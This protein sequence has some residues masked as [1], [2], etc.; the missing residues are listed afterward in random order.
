M[1]CLEKTLEFEVI[2]VDKNGNCGHSAT[3]TFAGK[4]VMALDSSIYINEDQASVDWAV[5]INSAGIEGAY[6]A[7]I[8]QYDKNNKLIAV[9]MEPVNF[10]NGEK[11]FG[12]NIVVRSN[13]VTVKLLLWDENLKPA[14]DVQS[15]TFMNANNDPFKGDDHVNVVFLGG[16]ITQG[17]GSSNAK[18]TCYAALTG[19]WFESTFKTAD[20]NV[21]WHNMGVGGTPS[22]YGLLRLN[23]DVVSKDP[24]IVFVEFAVNDSGSDTRRYMEGIVRSLLALEK[25]PYIVFL[26]TTNET[27]TTST[28]YHEQVAEFYGIPQISLKDAL[29]RELNGANAREAGYLKDSVHPSDLGYAVYFKE[30][31]KCLETGRYY[32]KPL[33]RS[34]KLVSQSTGVK[35]IF[36]SS[37]TADLSGG[38]WEKGGTAPKQFIKSVTPGDSFEFEFEGNILAL[39]HGLNIVGGKYDV[40]VDDVKV[41]TGET[42]YNNIKSNQLVLGYN[43]FNLASKGKHKAKIV[44]SDQ[45]NPNSSGNQVLIYNII[46]GTTLDY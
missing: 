14:A 30:I 37:Q 9:T 11:T 20:R 22:Q 29:K 45:K 39:E 18:E 31:K 34:D 43:N 28:A 26:Y 46:T 38:T 41:G 7:Y 16:S 24:D 19:K 35:T 32:Q 23:R 25:V 44:V 40:Y 21:T 36:T 6:T 27:Y 3:G 13:A 1:T 8:A 10:S 12:S 5:H 2:P 42:Y 15:V 4:V 17:T 33:N